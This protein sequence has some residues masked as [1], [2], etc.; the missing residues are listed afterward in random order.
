MANLLSKYSA[1]EKEIYKKEYLKL[2]GY[3]LNIN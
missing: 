3:F 2:F 1:G